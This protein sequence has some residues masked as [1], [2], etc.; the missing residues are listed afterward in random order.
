MFAQLA[1]TLRTVGSQKHDTIR[2]G[3]SGVNTVTGALLTSTSCMPSR[4]SH[5]AISQLSWP[6]PNTMCYAAQEHL[7][8][9]LQTLISY[10]GRQ[11]QLYTAEELAQYTSDNPAGGGKIYMAILGEVFDV[12][13]K[14]QFYGRLYRDVHPKSQLGFEQLKDC[15][16]S[17]AKVIVHA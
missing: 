10:L 13:A 6:R 11:D 12:S 17:T 16:L 14:P 7:P 9:R 2:R 5:E 15:A 8:P 3:L 4:T 1:M